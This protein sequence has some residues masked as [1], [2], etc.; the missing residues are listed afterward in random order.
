MT[1]WFIG[2]GRAA[3]M[4]LAWAAAWVP[5]GS[6][7]GWLIVGELEPEWIGGPLYAG[8]LCGGIFSAVAG[9]AG[10]RRRLDEMPLPRAGV[11]GV[12]SGLLAGGLWLVVALLS[13]P[14]QWLLYGA[15]VGSLALLSAMSGVT[16]AL[17]GRTG[18]NDGSA[19]AA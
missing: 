18:K 2:I 9:I 6:L 12:M 4:G 8:F 3:M 5:V 14:P 16:S 17:L 19:R 1:K 7:A 15:V 10:N 11:S 13:N